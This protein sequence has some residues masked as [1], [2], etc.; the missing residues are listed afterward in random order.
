MEN[1]N[2]ETQPVMMDVLS[3]ARMNLDKIGQ[4]LTKLNQILTAEEKVALEDEF[5]GISYSAMIILMDA[6]MAVE[7][8]KPSATL[9]LD[10]GEVTEEE[11]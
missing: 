10:T 1:E 7:E 5:T 6:Q 2:N 9:N 8:K 11:A 3:D 4:V